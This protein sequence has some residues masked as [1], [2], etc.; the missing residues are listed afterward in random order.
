MRQH[1]IAAALSQASRSLHRR[2]LAQ[3]GVACRKDYNLV[4]VASR[5]GDQHHSNDWLQCR[6]SDVQEYQV[7]SMGLGRPDWN[8]TVLEMLL[9][10]HAGALW[11]ACSIAMQQTA[12]AAC[13]CLPHSHSSALRLH[14][15]L[16][17]FGAATC[18]YRAHRVLV[19][20]STIPPGC[21]CA[22]IEERRA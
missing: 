18:D 12:H 4:S 6:D 10:Q 15:V 20:V 9:S 17:L 22:A 21:I 19:M 14:T 8:T 16:R 13:S 7:P 2:C 3:A 11:P 5:R 1:A